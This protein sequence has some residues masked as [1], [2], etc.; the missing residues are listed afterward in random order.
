ME[1]VWPRIRR[2]PRAMKNLSVMVAIVIG[3]EYSVY[4]SLS[5]H[6]FFLYRNSMVLQTH[7]EW[8]PLDQ[9]HT[10]TH[11]MHVHLSHTHTHTPLSLYWFVQLETVYV[12]TLVPSTLCCFLGKNKTKTYR[13]SNMAFVVSTLTFVP[14][15][16]CVCVCHSKVGSVWLVLRRVCLCE[17]ECVDSLFNLCVCLYAFPPILFVYS[18]GEDVF[19][20]CGD[21]WWLHRSAA[22]V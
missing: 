13:Q 2:E 7:S 14:F 3:S 22:S 4:L 15:C 5:G 6:N 21:R 12:S 19:Q 18:P 1:I 11:I 17:R 8:P 20:P 9:T 16:L 10:H